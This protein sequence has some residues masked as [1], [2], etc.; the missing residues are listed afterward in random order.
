MAGADGGDISMGPDHTF[1]GRK[2]G[3]SPEG[4]APGHIIE[5]EVERKVR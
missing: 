4:S 5:G 1:Q 2:C 3:F